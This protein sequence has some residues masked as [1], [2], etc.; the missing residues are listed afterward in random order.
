MSD[1]MPPPKPR[2]KRAQM[3]MAMPLLFGAFLMVSVFTLGV[4]VYVGFTPRG[5]RLTIRL[6]GACAVAAEPLVIGRI[7]AIGLGDP[8]VE[9]VPGALVVTATLPGQDPD[10]ERAVIPGLLGQAGL[11]EVRDGED[12]LLEQSGMTDA[13]LRLDENG[14]AMAVVELTTAA[15]RSLNEHIIAAPEEELGLFL[16]DVLVAMRPNTKRIDG[17]ELRII[18]DKVLPHARMAIAVDQ[19]LVL[20]NGPL[21]C[22]LTVGSVV[23]S[24]AVE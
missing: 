11:L 14:T 17:T 12:V 24:G 22:G 1:S 13:G 20:Q 23:E 5:D 8:V 16:D 19:V 15:A 2:P 7:D 3:F 6:E 10:R 4:L 21:P 9:Q 18:G